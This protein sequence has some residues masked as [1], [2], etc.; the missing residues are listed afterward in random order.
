MVSMKYL[1]SISA[2]HEAKC[3]LMILPVLTRYFT[4]K[5]TKNQCILEDDHA[6]QQIVRVHAKPFAI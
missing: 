6:W 5:K 4:S 3:R 1:Q 2:D